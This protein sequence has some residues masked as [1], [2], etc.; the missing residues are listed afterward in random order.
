MKTEEL[1]MAQVANEINVSPQ[2]TQSVSQRAPNPFNTK[3]AKYNTKDTKHFLCVK[4][5]GYAMPIRDMEDFQLWLGGYMALANLYHVGFWSTKTSFPPDFFQQN[6]LGS[7]ELPPD[8]PTS[9]VTSPLKPFLIFP[10][11]LLTVLFSAQLKHRTPHV[12]I[13]RAA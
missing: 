13:M 1:R 10:E 5:F 12:T 2:R 11:E 3:G 8:A 7:N 9:Y 6:N 4:D